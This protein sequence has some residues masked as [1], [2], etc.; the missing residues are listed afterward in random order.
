MTSTDIQTTFSLLRLL[1]GNDKIIKLR[2]NAFSITIN[3]KSFNVCYDEE[4]GL[5]CRAVCPTELIYYQE[6]DS[7]G[8]KWYIKSK[9]S[10]FS[11]Y[12][13]VH[14]SFANTNIPK[15]DEFAL[16]TWANS[17]YKPFSTRISTSDYKFSLMFIFD[18]EYPHHEF[19][20]IPTKLLNNILKMKW[21]TIK[22]I[23]FK[24][25]LMISQFN[26]ISE[27]RDIRGVMIQLFCLLGYY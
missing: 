8:S 14:D 22:K 15:N 5:I 3:G 12:Y 1:Y 11:Y 18:Y 6:Y 24:K 23:M 25:Y 26:G 17:I 16:E 19:K 7:G 20:M 21:N 9:S 2:D 13:S 10:S 4:K 27:C